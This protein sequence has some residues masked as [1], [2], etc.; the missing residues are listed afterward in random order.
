M[1]TGFTSPTKTASQPLPQNGVY[2][3]EIIKIDGDE[4]YVKIPYVS[5]GFSFGPCLVGGY[6]GGAVPAV[7]Q[8][9]ICGFLN[10]SLDEC[11]IFAPEL[12]ELQ[13]EGPA[14]TDGIADL[15]ITTAK[16]ADDAVT[17][18]KLADDAV[19]SAAIED[20][21]ITVADLASAV[22]NMLVPAGTIMATISSTADTGWLLLDGSTV[23]SASTLYPS[24]WSVAPASWKSGSSLVLPDMTDA[25]LSGDGN[26]T[27]GANAGSRTKSLSTSELPDHSHSMNHGHS[28]NFSANQSS[29]AHIVNPG[30]VGVSINSHSDLVERLGSY[31]TYHA[32]TGSAGMAVRHAQFGHSG[33][34]NIGNYTSGSADPSISISGSVSNFNGTTGYT[35]SGVTDA[36]DAFDIRGKHLAVKFQIKAH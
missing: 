19:T 28:D 36:G 13:A 23:S 4:V 14:G 35:G 6:T 11:V 16:L 25:M 15:A 26:T 21:T 5:A 29:H 27:L 18:D 24:L 33:S 30:T 22:Q 12:I 2:A 1:P 8:R 34:W 31:Q 9:V 3:G 17:A 7:G 10:N 32:P 20:G